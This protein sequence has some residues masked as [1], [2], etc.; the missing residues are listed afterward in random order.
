MSGADRKVLVFGKGGQLATA[1][2]IST[3]GKSN[4][5]FVSAEEADFLDLVSVGR[6]LE[7]HRPDQIIVCSAYTAVDKAENERDVCFKINVDAP[8]YIAKWCNKFGARMVI[9]ST[10]YVFSGSSEHAWIESDSIQPES[11][12]GKSKAIMESA[13]LENCPSALVLRVSWLFSPYGK[14][15]FL[16]AFDRLSKGLEMQIVDDQIG[17]P[18][19]AID[20]ANFCYALTSQADV[21]KLSGIFH[22]QPYI[23]D[24][25]H[26]GISWFEFAKRIAEKMKQRGI[27]AA[28]ISAVS[29]NVWRQ[30]HPNLAVRPNFSVLNGGYLRKSMQQSFI[31]GCLDLDWNRSLEKVFDEHSK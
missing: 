13:V 3:F 4:W 26:T 6:I 7:A 12:Y 16:T 8:T 20:L 30:K 23:G 18:I 28:P 2:E 21:I 15:F 1:L 31:S 22:F 19:S 14:N 17:I 10:D 5:I 29:T 11:V 27:S 25:S 24:F 9:F